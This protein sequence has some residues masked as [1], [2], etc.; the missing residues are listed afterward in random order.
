MSYEA[1]E[2]EERKTI[3]TLAIYLNDVAIGGG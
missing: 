2:E 3:T 1:E